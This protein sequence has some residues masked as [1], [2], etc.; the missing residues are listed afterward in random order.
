MHPKFEDIAK[1]KF[2]KEMLSINCSDL[3]GGIVQA[4]ARRLHIKKV[5]K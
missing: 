1:R 5:P 4:G 3:K 2:W